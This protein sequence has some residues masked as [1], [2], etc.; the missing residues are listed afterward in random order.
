M[1]LT[2]RLLRACSRIRN[3]IPRKLSLDAR[4]RFYSSRPFV[5]DPHAEIEEIDPEQPMVETNH[6]A[7]VTNDGCFARCIYYGFDMKKL[8]T[9]MH[10]QLREGVVEKVQK[11]TVGQDTDAMYALHGGGHVF[12]F[13]NGATVFWGIPEDKRVRILANASKFSVRK[14]GNQR[15]L[16][17]VQEES[18][19]AHDFEVEENVFEMFAVSYGLAQS[20]QLAMYSTILKKLTASP[21]SQS[22]PDTH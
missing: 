12:Y 8:H 13:S 20:S 9:Y 18:V 3:L 22:K 6:D 16:T 7:V 11:Y 1:A 17:A 14:P 5:P 21:S 15:V 4:L 19:F 10:E 2:R